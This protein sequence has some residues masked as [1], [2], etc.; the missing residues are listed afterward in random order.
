MTTET[1]PATTA[2][3]KIVIVAGQEFSVPGSYDNETIR[4][5]LVGQGFA[6]VAGATIKTG[7][8]TIGDQ[9]YDTVEFIKKAGT[10]GLGAQDLAELLTTVP[11]TRVLDR[12][13][14]PLIWRLLNGDLTFAEALASDDLAEALEQ[15]DPSTSQGGALCRSLDTL[16]ATAAAVPGW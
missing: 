15:I 9:E 14:G 6:D 11:A 12:Q 3:F 7:K 10:K 16:T 13:G 8:K 4:N 5:Y 1:T 2:E